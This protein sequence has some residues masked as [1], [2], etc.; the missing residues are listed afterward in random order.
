MD[1]FVARQPIFDID[2]KIYAYELLFRSG[3]SNGFPDIDGET[4]TTSL[5]SS[6]FFTV[7]IEKVGAGKLVF[8]NFTED[9]ILN[10]TP[11]L[12]PPQKMMVEILEDVS[13]GPEIVSACAELKE[14]G[15]LLA[16]D[17]FVYSK[18][19]DEL[20]HLSDIIKI[21][22]RLTPVAT[23]G[24]M[25]KT[26]KQYN[27][28]LLAEKVETYEEFHKAV[29]LGFDYF[30][31]YF[32]SKPEVLKNKDLS[33]SQMGLIRLI[34]QINSAEFDVD[35]LAELVAQDVSL[36]YKLLKYIN[37]SHFSRLQ[38][39]S[40]IRQAISFLGENGFK[41]FVSLIATSK[42]SENKPGELIRASIIRA[43]FLEQVG[44][45]LKKES[46]ELFLL[47]LFMSID[48]MLDQS[49][50][51]IIGK[52]PLSEKLKEA[53]VARKGELFI[54]VRLIET[55]EAGNWIAFRFAQK[56]LNITDTM[57]SDFYVEALGWADSFD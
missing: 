12:F 6:S 9:L 14:K 15:Y 28:K 52:M 33:S 36:T 35:S 27:C 10:R 5:L 24:E 39:L 41:M 57:I 22:F 1:V 16:L 29:E 17:D 42:L 55:Y 44:G 25:V 38:P 43:K 23:L 7:G 45:Y 51:N 40:S 56:K 32:F 4:A 47:G 48:A 13:P 19:F 11:Q 8:I 18:Q 34:S 21:D 46:S 3:E 50:E 20:L 2:K 26:L 53:L 54:F 37:S 30:Q 31:G 49:I